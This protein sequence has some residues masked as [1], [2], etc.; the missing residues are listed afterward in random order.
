MPLKAFETKIS[1]SSSFVSAVGK[2]VQHKLAPFVF[3]GVR[4]VEHKRLENSFRV[5]RLDMFNIKI[6]F[7]L[8]L[9]LILPTDI[10]SRAIS[11]LFPLQFNY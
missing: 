4:H 11:S 8:I 2:H 7:Y 9:L 1:C 3:A 10:N 5:C 6:A